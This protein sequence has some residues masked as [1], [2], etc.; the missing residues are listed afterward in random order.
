L[1]DAS[2]LY[3]LLVYGASIGIILLST[4]SRMVRWLRIWL[5]L[6]LSVPS[7][8]VFFR[9]EDFFHAHLIQGA[10]QAALFSLASAS[11][12]ASYLLVRKLAAM[13]SKT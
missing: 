8:V 4:A 9:G 1:I 12:L 2:I 3:F 13:R 7:L 5:A 10:Q 6:M 11:A